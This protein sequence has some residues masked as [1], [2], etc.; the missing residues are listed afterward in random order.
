MKQISLLCALTFLVF[1]QMS[2]QP[3]WMR[4]SA[5]SPDGKTVVFTYKGDLYTVASTGGTA[6][7]LTSHEAHD[8][9]PVWS[10][11]G[12]RLPLPLTDMAILISIPFQQQ[13]ERLKD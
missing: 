5:I 4:Y 9:M 11:D 6:M 10:H 13:V 8:F 3:N 12:N 2:A 1:S 7:A